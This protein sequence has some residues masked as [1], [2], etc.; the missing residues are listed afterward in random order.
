MNT[1]DGRDGKFEFDPSDLSAKVALDPNQGIYVAPA[2]D[3]TGASGAWVRQFSGSVD[4]RWFGAVADCTGYGIGTD[5]SPAI[6]AAIDLVSGTGDAIII[7]QGKFR[8]VTRLVV[9]SAIRISGTT[10]LQDSTAASLP[11]ADRGS[12]L[13]FDAG[14]GGILFRYT[15]DTDSSGTATNPSATASIVDGVRFI[16]G[17]AGSAS[18]GAYGIE[19]RARI[20]VQ[21]VEVRGFGD[22]GVYIRASLSGGD[23]VVYGN[24]NKSVLINIKSIGNSGDGF[25]LSG[26][27]AN[28]ISVV[29]CHSQGNAGWGFTDNGLIGNIYIGCVDEGNTT[30]GYRTLRAATQA[31]YFGC[32]VEGSPTIS[33]GAFCVVRGNNLET[34]AGLQ[35]IAYNGLQVRNGNTLQLNNTG[36]SATGGVSFDGTRFFFTA[37]LKVQSDI[38]SSSST[39]GIGYLTGAGGTVTQSTSKSNGVTLNKA[40]GQITMNNAALAAGTTVTFTLT[41][42]AIAANDI[43]LLNHISGGT[44]GAYTLNAQSAA[45]SASIN[46]RNVTTGSLSEPVVISYAVIKGATA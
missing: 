30:G 14:V 28:V 38:R 23:G 16:S 27:D 5:N 13:V 6:Q 37:G 22:H 32:E 11:D 8:C 12:T 9:K 3:I 33:L 26:N 35:Q 39:G 42:S 15:T 43:L 1:T 17:S 4:I 10:T 18:S 29:S 45:G 25:Y 41:N 7:P 44:A 40:T 36:N 46:V 21:N 24:A 20:S 2:S 31:S 34:L 19:S